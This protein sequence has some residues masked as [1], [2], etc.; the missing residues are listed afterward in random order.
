MSF[1]YSP[2]I[3]KISGVRIDLSTVVGDRSKEIILPFEKSFF[4]FIGDKG[5][6]IETDY[7]KKQ[8][9]LENVEDKF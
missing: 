9:Y 5:V 6:F 1:C 3:P 8:F 7:G 2:D 4:R